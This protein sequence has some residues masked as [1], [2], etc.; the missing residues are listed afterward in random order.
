MAVGGGANEGRED[1]DV[2]LAGGID[3]RSGSVTTVVERGQILVID[4]VRRR[5]SWIGG[6]KGN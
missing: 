4:R 2:D 5:R 1:G 6:Y 3:G